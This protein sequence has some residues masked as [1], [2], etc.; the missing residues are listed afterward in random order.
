MKVDFRLRIEPLEVYIEYIE[1]LR[2]CQRS[3]QGLG[4]LKLPLTSSS[5]LSSSMT[6]SLSTTLSTISFRLLMLYVGIRVA[7]NGV[8]LSVQME[9]VQHHVQ[10]T[11]KPWKLFFAGE[12]LTT[13]LHKNFSEPLCICSVIEIYFPHS[14]APASSTFAGINCSDLPVAMAVNGE[15]D[16]D[17]VNVPAQTFDTILVLDFG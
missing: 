10:G 3:L 2:R 12:R 7:C 4:T 11:C 9:V 5:P 15:T 8:L 1:V 6:A 17:V 13:A 16:G 14:R